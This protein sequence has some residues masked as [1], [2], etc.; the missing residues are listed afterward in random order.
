MG[1]EVLPFVGEVRWSV[2]RKAKSS[3]KKMLMVF[4]RF[5]SEGR[6]QQGKNNA[7]ELKST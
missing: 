7:K 1:E 2:G 4:I 3:T 5:N 6:K